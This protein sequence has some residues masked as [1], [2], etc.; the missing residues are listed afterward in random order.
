MFTVRKMTHKETKKVN[1]IKISES[2]IEF[3]YYTDIDSKIIFTSDKPYIMV[4]DVY[5]SGK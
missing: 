5:R 1:E 3:E 4:Q 2:N